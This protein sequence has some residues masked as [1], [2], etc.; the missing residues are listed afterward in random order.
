MV[1]EAVARQTVM[2]QGKYSLYRV[3][4]AVTAASPSVP[5]EVPNFKLPV[6][7]SARE[8]YTLFESFPSV[9]CTLSARTNPPEAAGT[10]RGKGGGDLGGTGAY[11]QGKRPEWRSSISSS[12]WDPQTPLVIVR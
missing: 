7:K 4:V 6:D 10:S 2:I 9:I 3:M 1:D 12:Q 8:L 11:L 5:K